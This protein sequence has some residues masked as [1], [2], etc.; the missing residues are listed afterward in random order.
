MYENDIN[1]INAADPT[2]RTIGGYNNFANSM[3]EAEICFDKGFYANNKVAVI[4]TD[5]KLT[6]GIRDKNHGGGSW[7][8]FRDFRLGYLGNFPSVVLANTLIEAQA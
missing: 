6:F 4:V 3:A 2:D 5:G 7:T 8:A 1:V